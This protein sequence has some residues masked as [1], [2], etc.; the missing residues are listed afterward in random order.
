MVCEVVFYHRRTW[1]VVQIHLTVYNCSSYW[2]GG[3]FFPLVWVFDDVGVCLEIYLHCCI[4]EGYYWDIYQKETGEVVLWCSL[5]M[6]VWL[7]QSWVWVY[8]ISRIHIGI[9]TTGW[10]VVAGCGKWC[11]LTLYW[12]FRRWEVFTSVNTNNNNKLHKNLKCK[13]L[14]I[15]YTILMYWNIQQ[16]LF[17]MW[18]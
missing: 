6:T 18:I 16:K 7:I 8:I 14:N 15:L 10:W 4:S 17:T 12:S 13:E 5:I 1:K 3:S 11:T 2:G 9:K